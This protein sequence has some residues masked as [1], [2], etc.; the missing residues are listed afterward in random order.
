MVIHQGYSAVIMRFES[1]RTNFL[2][3]DT[4]Q[5]IQLNDSEAAKVLGINVANTPPQTV[6]MKETVPTHFVLPVSGGNLAPETPPAVL[7]IGPQNGPQPLAANS[8]QQVVHVVTAA[9]KDITYQIVLPED[10]EV[11]NKKT[12]DL[13]LDM[14]CRVKIS[15]PPAT[16]ISTR[17]PHIRKPVQL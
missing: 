1:L 5:T 12:L 6:N 14:G 7:R 13:F 17:H 9:K 15:E 3:N 2:Q 16:A 10:I 4:L 8:V 11:V